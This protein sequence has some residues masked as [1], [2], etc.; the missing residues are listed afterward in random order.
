MSDHE[1]EN[2]D[3]AHDAEDRAHSSE[4]SGEGPSEGSNA[5]IGRY[6]GDVSAHGDDEREGLPLVLAPQYWDRVDD[7]RADFSLGGY[8]RRRPAVA[9]AGLA[10]AVMVFGST[11]LAVFDH[12]QQANMLAARAE[13]NARLAETVS[14]LNAR[15]QAV[16]ASKGRDELAELRR[17]V[18]DL[19][20]ASATSR[21]L[22]S[23][24]AQLSQR[25]EKLDREQGA[26]IDKL[27]DRV[28]HDNSTRTAEITARLDKLEKK[29]QPPAAAP[30]P[31]PPPQ[32]PKFGP[33]VAMDTTG[34]ID[35]PKPMLSGYV[36]LGAQDDTA[37]IGGRYGERAVRPGDFLPG[38]GRIERVERQGPNWVVVTDQGLIGP[39]YAAPD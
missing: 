24:I 8:L 28:D 23:A 33:N 17:S 31:P 38:A 6:D 39:A 12:H 36:V 11:G 37:L 21:E 18:G 34:S 35:R 15:L 14:T 3:P 4:P 22:G 32:P 9:L 25:V 16:E 20:S 30:P 10:L 2:S 27:G 7:G 5:L 19:K 1:H 29:P 26:K 13:E